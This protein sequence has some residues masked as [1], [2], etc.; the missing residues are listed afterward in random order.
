MVASR[1]LFRPGVA[2]V[3]QIGRRCPARAT[4]WCKPDRNG[5]G[6]GTTQG[7]PAFTSKLP[8]HWMVFN[9]GGGGSSAP[10]RGFPKLCQAMD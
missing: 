5:F 7:Q 8:A 10:G 4:I 6:R 9:P 3:A 2:V 1:Q